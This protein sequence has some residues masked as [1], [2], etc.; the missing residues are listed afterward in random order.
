MP[1]ILFNKDLP[2]NA[3]KQV[4][5][6]VAE[7]ASMSMEL[8]SM[9]YWDIF[10]PDTEDLI[11]AKREHLESIISTLPWVA[12]VD[13]FQH[14]MYLNPE[15]TAEQRKVVWK[16]IVTEF[17]NSITDWTNL[18]E[19]LEYLWQ[20]QLHVFEVPF[21][22]IEYGMA[23]LGAIAVWKNYKE[24]PEKG[25]KAYK[26]A[27]KLGYTKPIGAIYEA[28]GIKF[29]FSKENIKNLIGFIQSELSKLKL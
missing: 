25:Y 1:Y 3:F 27:L 12:T 22:Y 7:L 2:L 17:S 14:W 28:V 19:S 13:K 18:E 24:N 6:E 20:K 8:I 11:R 15:H 29:D 10:F 23:Q 16:S 4:P 26:E 21:Y 5:S 9:E